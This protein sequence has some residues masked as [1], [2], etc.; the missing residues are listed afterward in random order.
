M[1]TVARS[2]CNPRN[3]LSFV[4]DRMPD[5]HPTGPGTSSPSELE[6][7]SASYENTKACNELVFSEFTRLT[8]S[9][10]WLKE[11]RDFVERNRFGYGQRAFHYSWW[12]MVLDLAAAKRPLCLLEI[13]VFKGQILSLVALCAKKLDLVPRL[14]GVSP[15]RGNR[16]RS[17]WLSAAR[18]IFDSEYR[19]QH[20]LGNLHPDGDHV[21]DVARL[22]AEFDLDFSRVVPVRGLST[23]P[24]VI[25]RVRSE[26]FTLVFIDGDH[27]YEVARSDILNFAPL[28]EPGG[29]LVVDDAANDLPGSGYFKGMKAVSRACREV[30][31]MSDFSNVLNVGHNRIFRRMR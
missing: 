28:V 12:L 6:R 10:P 9:V 2:Q 16:E 15:F 8:D 18:V 26:R 19:R 27:S 14:V 29:Y 7:R 31:R 22:F 30:D 25:D 20:R 3:A 11:H 21:T 4:R 17:W 5:D 13:G 1:P 24:D 23:A